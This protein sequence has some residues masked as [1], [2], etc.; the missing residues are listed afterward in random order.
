[1]VQCVPDIK[2]RQDALEGFADVMDN[3]V[4]KKRYSTHQNLCILEL[5][6]KNQDLQ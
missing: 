3:Y 2:T 6:N 1:M 4:F 5:G